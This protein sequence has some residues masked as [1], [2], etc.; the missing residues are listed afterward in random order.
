MKI[1]FVGSRREV[2]KKIID[3]DLKLVDSFVIEKSFAEKLLKENKIPYKLINKNN[4]DNIFTKI[5]EIDFDIL[6][7]NGCPFIIPVREIKKENQLFIN[8]HP[9]LLPFYKGRHPINGVLLNNEK[10]TGVTCHFMDDNIDA[11]DIVFQKKIDLSDDIDID[12]LYQICFN[13]E[14]MVFEKSYNILKNKDIKYIGKKQDIINSYYSR[15]KDDRKIYF[16]KMS[17]QKIYN[18]IRAFS[19]DKLGAIAFKENKDIIF[20]E[21]EMIKNSYLLERY[22]KC[23]PGEILMIYCNKILI[24]TIDGI[25]K[26]KKYKALPDLE[27]GLILK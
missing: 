24:K 19:T 7:S 10:F 22:S 26:I 11:G 9:S 17:T 27:E 6:V 16:S 12:L 4:K 25:I 23:K 8:I 14:A 3:L 5:K 18:I 15:K 13:I 1:I 20:F 21:S 2:L